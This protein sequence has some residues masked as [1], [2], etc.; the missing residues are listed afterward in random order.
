MSV[1]ADD[2]IKIKKE[3]DD[4][5]DLV[6]RYRT[7]PNQ[8]YD[9]VGLITDANLK[10]EQIGYQ[11]GIA[12]CL[13]NRGMGAFILDHDY[14]KSDQLINE[15]R[16][17]FEKQNNLKWIANADLTQ[18][19]IQN[20][21]G[22]PESALYLGL[23]GIA[24]YENKVPD[25]DCRMANYVVGT[26]YKDL[27]KYDEA[28][29]YYYRGIEIKGIHTGWSAR[30]YASLSNILND[31]GE[32]EK[33]LKLAEQ[34]LNLL[35]DEN[36]AIGVSRSLSDLAKIHVNL[37]EYE[38]ALSYYHEAL[39]IRKSIDIKHFVLGSLIDLANVYELKNDFE[40]ALKY[41]LEALPIALTTNH[42]TRLS[43]IY[44]HLAEIYK[45]K[46]DF[47]TAIETYEKLVS[48]NNE[49]AIKE[50]ESKITLSENKLLK[51]KEDE[52]ERLKNVE[53]K[54]AY[55]LIAE[56]NKEITDS[57]QYA[58]RIQ[59]TILADLDV[60]NRNWKDYFIFFQPKDIVSGD[61][62]WAFERPETGDFYFAVCDSTGHGVPGAFM[63]LLNTNFLNE[64]IKEK[65]LEEPGKIFDYVRKRLVESIS[66][67]GQKDGFDGI[68]VRYNAGKNLFQ[69]AAG[70][71][72]PILITK[73]EIVTLPADKM[74]IGYGDKNES[75]QTH[76]IACSSGGM[77]YLI[78]D[79][80]A[81]QFGGTNVSEGTSKGKKF[82]L[83]NL[84]NLFLT[85]SDKD[86]S[87]QEKILKDTFE[88]W[89]GDLEQI[90][91]VCVLGVRV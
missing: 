71:N 75:F 24:Y 31:C 43:F 28:R 55:D 88:N 36:N 20:S 11:Y 69:Y 85:I 29:R 56:K 41:Y 82:K 45:I 84:K 68:L 67:E 48:I 6:W 50:R 42:A 44:Q 18:A 78:T 90:D 60:V 91:D 30:L 37:K 7:S 13:L 87:E 65:R 21:T 57:I 74:P 52:I 49:I 77:L 12:R 16:A 51:E 32:Y 63:S 83:A 34:G 66:K 61:F 25:D 53:L 46:K 40:N 64:A 23:R 22:R 1:N 39:E 70:N 58:K 79:G 73:K 17:M 62:Y 72:A 2:I 35:R 86:L 26:I 8:D 15:A 3:I 10:A 19:I 54:N 27:K 89:K 4:A 5:N 47:A 9:P 38:K 81:D 76:D 14:E 33:A 59:K 80:Y